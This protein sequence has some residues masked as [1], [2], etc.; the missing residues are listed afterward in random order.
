MASGVELAEARSYSKGDSEEK[1]LFDFVY[2]YFCQIY[3][4][5]DLIDV[6]GFVLWLHEAVN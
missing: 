3:H 6:L 1:Y 4:C 5:D 2:Q